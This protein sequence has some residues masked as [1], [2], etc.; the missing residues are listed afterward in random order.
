[1][2]LNLALHTSTSNALIKAKSSSLNNKLTLTQCHDKFETLLFP[3][4]A[5]ESLRNSGYFTNTARCRSKRK[6]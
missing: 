1:M 3:M 4:D 2:G 5:R 6:H